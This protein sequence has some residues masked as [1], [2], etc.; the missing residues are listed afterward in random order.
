MVLSCSLPGS[1][2]SC[3]RDLVRVVKSYETFPV[4]C[5][6]RQRIIETMRFL[7]CRLHLGDGETHPVLSERIDDNDLPI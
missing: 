1:R 6:E 2:A 3:G 4:F 5:V 7:E